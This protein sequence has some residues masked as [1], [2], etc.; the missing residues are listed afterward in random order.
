[1]LREDFGRRVMADPGAVTWV[2]PLWKVV[3]SNKALLAA[4]W[5]LYPGHD[6]LLPSYLDGPGPLTDWVAKPLHGREGDGIRIHA[7]G[8]DQ[9]GSGHYGGEG[10]CYQQ[11][12][13]LPDFDGNKAVV[14]SWVVGDHAAGIGI[15]E[16]DGWVTDYYA[17]FVP[18]VM[19]SPAPSEQQREQWLDED[20]V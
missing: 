1:M 19:T 4:L 8:I 6:N 9:L 12:C 2:E 15:R 13:P 11:W 18:H 3:L 10:Y 7:D 20:L 5:H 17:R 16:S 14:G